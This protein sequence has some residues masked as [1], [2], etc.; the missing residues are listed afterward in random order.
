MI[1]L[2]S[3]EF[4]LLIGIVSAISIATDKFIGAKP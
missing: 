2:D 4:F 3:N 1:I